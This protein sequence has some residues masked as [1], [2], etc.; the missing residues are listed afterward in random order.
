M[1][2]AVAGQNGDLWLARAQRFPP[3]FS[4][5]L[6][7]PTSTPNP[8]PTPTPISVPSPTQPTGAALTLGSSGVADLISQVDLFAL[9]KIVIVGLCVMWALIIL[10]YIDREF[11][12][13]KH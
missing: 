11:E 4:N 1:S 13:K 6:P 3:R 9:A 5:I 8:S 10:F 12:K 7:E 2:C